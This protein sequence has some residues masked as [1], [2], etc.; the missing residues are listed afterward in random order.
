MLTSTYTLVALSVE[1]TSARTA[2][3]AL[4]DELQA[5]PAEPASL[6]ASRAAELGGMLRRVYDDCHWR[7]LDQFLVPALRCHTGAADALLD[8][9]EALSS[10]A[11]EAM[12]EAEAT[13]RARAGAAAE[14][15]GAGFLGAALRSVGALQLRLEREEHE[16]F[17]LA[18]SA[19][20]NDAWFAL[21]NQMMAH[22]VY[23]RERR[24]MPRTPAAP[25][26]PG[27]GLPVAGERLQAESA[28]WHQAL[29]AAH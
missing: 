26:T 11:A 5:L 4:L 6:P 7:K 13:V 16:L 25:G 17:P 9:L 24:A 27:P 8:E 18:R 29:L 19:V 22:D 21:A 12:V 10:L 1:Q 23:A 3:Q 28:R 15:D 14:V 20:G 2:L